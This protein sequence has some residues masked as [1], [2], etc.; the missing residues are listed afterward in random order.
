MWRT[1]W[2]KAEEKEN[3]KKFKKLNMI[4]KRCKIRK[5]K[6]NIWMKWYT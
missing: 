6:S 4:R 5:Q 1:G 3:G 2:R